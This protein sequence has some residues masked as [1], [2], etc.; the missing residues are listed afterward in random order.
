MPTHGRAPKPRAPALPRGPVKQ[1][2]TYAA[3]SPDGESAKVRLLREEIAAGEYVIDARAIAD[4]I[5]AREA[6]PQKP[7]R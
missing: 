1:S 7:S 4:A 2:G 3:T 5:L 6:K